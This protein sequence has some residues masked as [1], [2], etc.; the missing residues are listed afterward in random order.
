MLTADMSHMN[1]IPLFHATLRLQLFRHL[2]IETRNLTEVYFVIR[3]DGL[4]TKI[5]PL[6]LFV[7]E[8]PTYRIQ[9]YNAK[10]HLH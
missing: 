1:D 9:S 5:M 3:C 4:N 6:K 10:V 2:E 8:V 7:Y